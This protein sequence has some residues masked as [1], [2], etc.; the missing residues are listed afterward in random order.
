MDT[1]VRPVWRNRS[2]RPSE[3]ILIPPWA[4]I[5][6]VHFAGE[7]GALRLSACTDAV[8]RRQKPLLLAIAFLDG[9]IRLK[10]HA[11]GQVF[12]GNSVSSSHRFAAAW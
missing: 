4:S 2:T 8:S 12:D 3:D 7:P 5:F 11:L 10:K 1:M 6:L 9:D